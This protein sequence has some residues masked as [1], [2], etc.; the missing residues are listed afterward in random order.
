MKCTT[1]LGWQYRP[2]STLSFQAPP[3]DYLIHFHGPLNLS[4][5]YE[6]SKFFLF[7]YWILRDQGN[8]QLDYPELSLY[9]IRILYKLCSWNHAIWMHLCSNLYPSLIPL[10]HSSRNI[11]TEICER[12]EWSEIYGT[13]IVL[14][15]T[16]KN[17]MQSLRMCQILERWTEL[18]SSKLCEQCWSTQKKHELQWETDKCSMTW[19]SMDTVAEESTYSTGQRQVGDGQRRHSGSKSGAIPPHHGSFKILE[20]DVH[21]ETKIA[22]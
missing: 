5:F 21:S 15:F 2:W 13:F 9:R 18:T 20:V 4:P 22:L 8:S 3:R 10:L 17:N 12:N 6:V 11:H 14:L 7:P 1:I 19:I 16:W